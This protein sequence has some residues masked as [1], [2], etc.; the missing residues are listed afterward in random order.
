MRRDAER[1]DS[2]QAQSLWAPYYFALSPS[3]DAE[4]QALLGALPPDDHIKTLAWAFDDYAAGD[5]SRRQTLRYYVALLHER[6]GRLAEA[7]EQLAALG[8][9]LAGHPGLLQD[10]VQASLKR[11]RR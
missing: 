4:R 5:Q 8:Q 9:E 10:A 11:L 7:G 2:R 1:L 6:A 3:R